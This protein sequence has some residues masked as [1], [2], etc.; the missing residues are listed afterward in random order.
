V[1]CFDPCNQA[2]SFWESQGTSSSHF[3]ECEF[4]PHTCLKV[5]LRQNQAFYLSLTTFVVNYDIK[6]WKNRKHNKFIRWVSFNLHK[7][8]KNYYRKLLILFKPFHGLENNLKSK[9]VSWKGV[10]FNVKMT[11]KIKIKIKYNLNILKDYI[12]WWVG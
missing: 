4:H 1:R 12:W 5:E 11:W 10:C 3:W 7:D 6:S 2:L 9:H 8:A